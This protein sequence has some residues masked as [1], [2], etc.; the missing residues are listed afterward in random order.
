LRA[1]A[2][3]FPGAETKSDLLIWYLLIITRVSIK[4][5]PAGLNLGRSW[6]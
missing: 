5:C 1:N 2:T 6:T 3:L 4:W